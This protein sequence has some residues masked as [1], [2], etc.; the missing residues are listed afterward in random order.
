MDWPINELL[1]FYS[2]TRIYFYF[3]SVLEFSKEMKNASIWNYESFI[4]PGDS[5]AP[6]NFLSLAH[7]SNAVLQGMEN[8]RG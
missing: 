4:F 6:G 2:A 7:Y 5:C 1:D 8:I 3:N